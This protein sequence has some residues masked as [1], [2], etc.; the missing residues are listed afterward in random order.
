[1]GPLAASQIFRAM[2][3]DAILRPPR[4][5]PVGARVSKLQAMAH[6]SEPGR[7]ELG[8]LLFFRSS[9]APGMGC[10][11]LVASKLWLQRDKPVGGLLS[12]KSGYN[13]ILL[14]SNLDSL[15]RFAIR[16]PIVVDSD[17]DSDWDSD[18]AKTAAGSRSDTWSATPCTDSLSHK[19]GHIRPIIEEISILFCS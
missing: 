6:L 13:S 2:R 8:A 11:A 19:G 3:V 1:M 16:I 9:R 4:A 10:R 14:A 15:I 17:C 18:T 5:C 7:S 12:N